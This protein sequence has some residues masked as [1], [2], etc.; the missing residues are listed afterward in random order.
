MDESSHDIDMKDH[1]NRD[2][3]RRL[4]RSREVEE[5]ILA[6]MAK[7]KSQ[8]RILEEQIDTK[9]LLYAMSK[10]GTQ[11]EQIRLLKVVDPIDAG[12]SNRVS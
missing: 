11:L 8:R 1:L 6:T 2:D 10:F 9:T 3:F 4:C 12:V 7:A 5:Q